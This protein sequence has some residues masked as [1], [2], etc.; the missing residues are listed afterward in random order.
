V[1]IGGGDPLGR[2]RSRGGGKPGAVDGIDPGLGVA[3]GVLDHR[4]D[5]AHAGGAI[6]ENVGELGGHGQRM[7]GGA[8]PSLQGLADGSSKAVDPVP[9]RIGQLP[10]FHHDAVANACQLEVRAADIPA[11]DVAHAV[12]TA[13]STARGVSRRL[14][15]PSGRSRRP[16][17]SAA[18]FNPMLS[19]S[20]T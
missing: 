18:G 4:Q 7:P 14:S 16:S 12:G 3:D 2:C 8:R 5:G 9:E 13:I 6:G 10:D 17:T 1:P 20:P 19:R 15:A 11:D